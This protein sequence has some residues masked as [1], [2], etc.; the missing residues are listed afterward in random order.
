MNLDYSFKAIQHHMIKD[1]SNT[2]KKQHQ[3]C[4]K[5]SDSW[6]KYW[7]DK[8]NDTKL[9]ND[10]KQLSDVFMTELNPIFVRLSNDALLQR[11]LKGLNSESK[12]SCKWDPLVQMPKGKILQCKESPDCCLPNCCQ[13]QH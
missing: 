4:P 5:S 7:K 9:Y 6:C 1:T 11:C 2:L 12:R 3:Y 13:F 10:D 8:A